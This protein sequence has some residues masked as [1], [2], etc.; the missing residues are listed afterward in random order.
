MTFTNLFFKS[1]SATNS[2]NQVTSTT[3]TEIIGSKAEVQKVSSD[4]DLYYFF[5]FSTCPYDAS[6][7]EKT[8]LHIKL[9]RSND[10][11]SSNIVDVPNCNYNFSTDTG[12]GSD[13]LYKNNNIFFIVQNTGNDS[14]RLVARSYGSNTRCYLHYTPHFDGVITYT[15]KYY[16]PTLIVKEI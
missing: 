12:G 10:N 6:G 5:S 4:S 7:Y 13:L 15:N 1:S 11:F 9:Q 16:Y 14:L 3:Y 2:P 8:R